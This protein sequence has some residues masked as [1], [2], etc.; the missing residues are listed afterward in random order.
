MHNYHCKWNLDLLTVAASF[1]GQPALQSFMVS[2]YSNLLVL[3]I[4]SIV[5][6]FAYAKTLMHPKSTDKRAIARKVT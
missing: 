3:D 2:Y 6:P 1:Q 5:Q 4:I